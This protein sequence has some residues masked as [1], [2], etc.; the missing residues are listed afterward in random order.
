[1]AVIIDGNSLDVDSVVRVARAGEEVRIDPAAI[2]RVRGCRSIVD[3]MVE[4]KARIYGVTTGIGELSEVV[5]TTEQVRSFQKYLVYSHAAGCGDPVAVDDARAAMLSRVNVLCRGH[6]G[7]RPVVVQTLVDMLN[8][9]V[10]PVMCQKG[11]VGASGDL[12]PLGQM[13]LVVMG[14]GEAFLGG[15]R[16]SGAEAMDKA[17]VATVQFQA[18]DGLAVINGSNLTA[19]MGALQVHDAAAWIKTSEIAAA[20]SLSALNGNMQAFDERIHRVRGYPGAVASSSNIRRLTEGG[21]FLGQKGK[22]VQDAYSLRS[23]PQ[24]TGAARDTLKFVRHT[25]EI[26]L[27]GVG[28]NPIFFEDDGGTCVTGANF[29]GTPLAFGLDFLGIAVATVCVL[30]ERRLNR[31][32]NPNLSMGLPPFLTK[33]AGMFSGM[34]LAQY[35]ADSMVCENRLLSGPASTG[36]IP[37]AADQEDFVSMSMTSA[38][39]NK[40][41]LSNACTVLAIEMMAAAQALDFRELK[42]GGGVLAAHEVLRKYVAH[43]DEDRPLHADINKLTEVVKSGEVLR[44]VEA[45]VGPLE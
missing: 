10:T 16:M 37:A 7:L 32:V 28:D 34:M 2:E 30:S 36:S 21:G 19:G 29:Q 33:G 18:R 26:E 43:L 14:E 41:I 5:L 15:A 24:V 40:Q 20:M 13:A 25:F 45:A 27:N 1:M 9:G 6:S 17:G 3:R 11:S 42:L 39:K 12:S 38:T 31:L 23:T 22:R 35:T 8:K 4:D 44:A